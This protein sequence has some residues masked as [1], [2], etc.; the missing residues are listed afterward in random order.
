MGTS[1]DAMGEMMSRLQQLELPAHVRRA[2]EAGGPDPVLG[3]MAL[4]DEAARRRG[5]AAVREA[6]PITLGRVLRDADTFRRD[7]G[8][9]FSIEHVLDN[10]DGPGMGVHSDYIRIFQHGMSNTHLEGINHML[11]D[12]TVYGGHRVGTPEA[13][14]TDVLAWAERGWVTRGVLVDV[15]ALRGVEF[16]DWDTPVTGEEIERSLAQAGV[17]VERGDAL[18]VHMGYDAAAVHAREHGIDIDGLSPDFKR[19]GLGSSGAQWLVEHGVSLLVYDFE[20]ANHPSEPHAAGQL[21]EWAIGQGIVATADLTAAARHR[22]ATGQA[23]GLLV[24]APLKIPGGTGSPVN[25]IWIV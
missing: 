23:D 15:P 13:A 17:V 8:R 14:H 1:S 21:L 24:V 9:T 4:I 6:R 7:G 22:A 25:P 12:G 11:W 18:M 3:T 10:G 16:V 20:D 19:P 5:L 2:A